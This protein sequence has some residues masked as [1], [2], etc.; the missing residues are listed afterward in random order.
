LLSLLPLSK[1]PD[2]QLAVLQLLPSVEPEDPGPVEPPARGTRLIEINHPLVLLPIAHAP[3]EFQEIQPGPFHVEEVIHRNQLWLK[4]PGE[5]WGNAAICWEMVLNIS[6]PKKSSEKG[7]FHTIV[8]MHKA[9]GAAIH[10]KPIGQRRSEA[11]HLLNEANQFIRR[12]EW[13]NALPLLKKASS[14][15]PE[16]YEIVYRWVQA[17][18]HTADDATTARAVKR[19]LQQNQWSFDQQEMLER[20]Q[21]PILK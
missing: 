7:L 5:D 11:W 17:V 2:Q 13:R 3:K 6:K 16:R 4:L 1:S 12:D 8:R 10:G 19:A 21:M 9:V 18:R 14:T 15:D 20:L